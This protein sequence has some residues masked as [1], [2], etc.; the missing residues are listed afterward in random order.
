MYYILIT[1]AKIKKTKTNSWKLKERVLILKIYFVFFFW[2][3]YPGC[4]LICSAVNTNIIFADMNST[5]NTMITKAVTMVAMRVAT[6][7]MAVVDTVD[8]EDMADMVDMDT[9]TKDTNTV[10]MDTMLDIIMSGVIMTRVSM[11]D[12]A[13]TNMADM[14]VRNFLFQSF[15]IRIVFSNPCFS[16]PG[17]LG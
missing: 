7:V 4:I 14:A 11:V 2:L 15:W 3:S 16:I 8:T 10:T 9:D 5:K 6:A 17:K 13:V 12:M 1:M